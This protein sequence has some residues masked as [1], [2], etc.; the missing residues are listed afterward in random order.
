M[1]AYTPIYT[2][3]YQYTFIPIYLETY[4]PLT[5]K[6]LN[7]YIPTYTY[8]HIYVYSYI[9]IY[10]DRNSQQILFVVATMDREY[11]PL[12]SKMPKKT[13]SLERLK[14]LDSVPFPLIGL[15][16]LLP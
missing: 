9:P 6:C 14:V 12:S 11:A 5:H 10:L 3:I 2:P 1:H 4:I 7:I 13:A 16:P 15:N 8:I